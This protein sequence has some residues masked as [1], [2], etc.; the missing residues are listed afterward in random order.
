MPILQKAAENSA[1]QILSF[2][3]EGKKITMVDICKDFTFDVAWRQIIGLKLNDDESEEFRQ[4]VS[5]WLSIF[6]N[7]LNFFLPKFIFKRTKGYKSKKYLDSVIE[8]KIELLEKHGPDGSAL[9]AMVFNTDDEEGNSQK[10]HLT[11]EQVIDNT[12]LLII[13]GT[14]T[15][16][17]TLTNAM[18]ILGMHPDAWHKIAEEQRQLVS[19]H[20]KALTKEQIDKECPYLEAVIKEVMRLI[21]ISAG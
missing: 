7:Y 15:S 1:D 10:R 6:S 12:G 2:A 18:Q 4:A 5:N 14:E 9:S 21:P 3:A 17:N 8:S 16:S 13:A 19:R 11:R 20:G